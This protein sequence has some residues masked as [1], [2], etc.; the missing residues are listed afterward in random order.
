MGRGISSGVGA[1]AVALVLAVSAPAGAEV[2][3]STT[4]QGTTSQLTPMSFTVDYDPGTQAFFV[5]RTTF[6]LDLDCP[7]G[8]VYIYSTTF[9]SGARVAGG[10]FVA[11]NLFANQHDRWGGRFL[12][13]TH[14]RGFAHFDVPAL[15]PAGALETC[16]ADVTWDASV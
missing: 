3:A 14:V 16:T 9:T 11:E 5:N 1:V 13:S 8:Q 4:F 12:S 2:R 15:S 7:S 6:E 10:R